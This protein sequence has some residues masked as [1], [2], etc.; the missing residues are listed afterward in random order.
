[1]LVSNIYSQTKKLK[2]VWTFEKALS[3]KGSNEENE[4][5][6]T[7]F[8]GYQLMF[9]SS[10]FKFPLMGGKYEYGTWKWID[11]TKIETKTTRGV[12]SVYKITFLSPDRMIFYFS[13]KKSGMQFLRTSQ[14]V[15][16]ESVS[17][18][19]DEI[20]GVLIAE[21]LFV[22]E[23]FHKGTLMNGKYVEIKPN[24]ATGERASW[25]FKKNGKFI[26]KFILGLTFG[27]NWRISD[28]DNVLYIESKN[29]TESYKVTKLSETELVIFNPKV[30]RKIYFEK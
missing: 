22:G 1:M 5:F 20:E 28:E 26:N 17:D 23:W 30:N 25:E 29:T 15:S 11:K 3:L 4:L 12:T 16:I 18:V 9:D 10:N 13:N 24:H 19:L 27:G 7:M 14:E 8:K 21:D 6:N 2:G